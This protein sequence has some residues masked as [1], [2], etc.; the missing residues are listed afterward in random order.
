MTGEN[1]N[2]FLEKNSEET[3]VFLK[4]KVTIAHSEKL[5]ELLLQAISFEQ[6]IRIDLADLHDLDLTALQLLYAIKKSSEDK[7][8]VFSIHPIHE[9]AKLKM[10]ESH[11]LQILVPA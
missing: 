9:Q 2:C 11:M 5:K 10:D 3:I 8:L 7:E 6:N 4:N 1:E